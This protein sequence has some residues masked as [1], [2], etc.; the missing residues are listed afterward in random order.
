M[1]LILF[2]LN[3]DDT[4]RSLYGNDFLDDGLLSVS[5][6]SQLERK[7]FF[8]KKKRGKEADTSILKIAEIR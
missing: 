8:K 3:I 2:F 5:N 6:F 4:D 7:L 1:L